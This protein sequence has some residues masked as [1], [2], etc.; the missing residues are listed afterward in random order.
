MD[1]KTIKIK[2]SLII[3]N[4]NK[5]GIKTITE[6]INKKHKNIEQIITIQKYIR[7][8]LIRKYILIPSSYYQTKNWRKNQKWYNNGKS[9]EC[10]KYQINLIKKIIKN[11]LIKTDHRIN[12]ESNKIISNKNP[13][14]NDDG[15]EWSEN[16]DGVIVKNNNKYYFN[17]KFVSDKGGA[18]TRNLK[19]VYH[20]IGYQMEFL[21]KF[22]NFN[23][24]NI[25]F[26]NIL[27]GDT[28]FHNMNKFKYLINKE[29]YENISKYIFIGNLHDFQK[30]CNNL[31]LL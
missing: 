10:E 19:E 18:Q 15:Y 29:K 6:N 1:I 28:S 26:I 24:N 14:I 17:L 3:D 12:I 9:N 31:I 27:D 16:F 22:N 5:Y 7:G 2:N 13:M 25:Y 30:F 4:A 20:F 11:K 21:L 23:K 8:Y